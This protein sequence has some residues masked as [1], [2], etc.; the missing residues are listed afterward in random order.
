M[1]INRQLKLKSRYIFETIR[2]ILF[3][4]ELGS[5]NFNQELPNVLIDFRICPNLLFISF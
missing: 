2:L 1:R 3:M 4:S 5:R